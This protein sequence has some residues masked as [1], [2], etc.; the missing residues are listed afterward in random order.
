[1]STAAAASTRADAR[2][3]EILDDREQTGRILRRM[4]NLIDEHRW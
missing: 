2:R 3:D 1:V 4:F